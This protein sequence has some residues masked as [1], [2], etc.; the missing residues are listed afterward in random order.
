MLNIHTD[1][2]TAEHVIS[3]M[4]ILGKFHACSLAM[5]H[6][7][8]EAFAEMITNMDE[9]IFEK[10]NINWRNTFNS[11]SK[12]VINAVRTSQNESL[13]N[14]LLK[15]YERDSY[16]IILKCIDGDRAEPYSVITHGDCWMN[17]I[18]FKYNEKSQSIE[19]RLIDWQILRYCSPVCDI[20]HFIFCCTT[21]NLRDE[22]YDQFLNSYYESLSNHLI[23]WKIS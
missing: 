1:T 7:K 20:V 22:Y 9:V 13:T 23:R 3:V 16:D 5:K 8:P 12:A 4:Q 14:K 19:A 2:L 15:F 18:L 6:Q 17:N 11:L 21:K 10:N